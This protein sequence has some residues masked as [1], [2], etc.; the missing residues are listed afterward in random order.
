VELGWV[1]VVASAGSAADVRDG[2]LEGSF[3]IV[4]VHGEAFLGAYC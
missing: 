2:R 3:V 4:Q 1:L